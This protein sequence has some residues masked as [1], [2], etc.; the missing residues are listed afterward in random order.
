VTLIRQL[1]TAVWKDN[2][3]EF[4]RTKSEGHF[5]TVAALL[6][7]ARNS[8][9]HSNPYPSLAEG[10]NDYTHHVPGRLR[11]TVSDEAKVLG[12]AMRRRVG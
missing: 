3:R 11:I 5:D 2:R 12:A 10:V 8:N 9:R 7:F 1:R 6:Y 4:E